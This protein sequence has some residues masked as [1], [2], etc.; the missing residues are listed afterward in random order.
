[1]LVHEGRNRFA[2]NTLLARRKQS[3]KFYFIRHTKAKVEKSNLQ[4][5]RLK[6]IGTCS[7]NL[8]LLIQKNLFTKDTQGMGMIVCITKVFLLT[9]QK[10][11]EFWFLSDEVNSPL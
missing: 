8:F 3:F 6:T 5:G 4:K 9:R 1:M 10:L 2:G 11:C 7:Y